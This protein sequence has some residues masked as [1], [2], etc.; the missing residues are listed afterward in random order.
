[1]VLFFLVHQKTTAHRRYIDNV[2]QD[3][4]NR[5]VF[6]MAKVHRADVELLNAAHVGSKQLILIEGVSLMAL[7]E[8]THVSII[9][10][11]FQKSKRSSESYYG[12]NETNTKVIVPANLPI[13]DELSSDQL[14]KRLIKPG[15]FVVVHIYETNSQTLK[16][17]PLF[18]SSITH[19]HSS[20]RT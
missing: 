12:R 5:R 9:V 15:D 20:I 19:F 13:L 8:G 16:G 4:K 1:M 7:Q 3:V 18:F 11:D 2:P 6:E 10:S 14:S 17:T